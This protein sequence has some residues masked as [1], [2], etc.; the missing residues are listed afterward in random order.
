MKALTGFSVLVNASKSTLPMRPSSSVGQPK[1]SYRT[2]AFAVR[3]G[4]EPP[5]VGDEPVEVVEA[6]SL[7]CD[8]KLSVAFPGETREETS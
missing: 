5:L 1:N 7:V 2:P 6:E 4:T 8:A 3:V